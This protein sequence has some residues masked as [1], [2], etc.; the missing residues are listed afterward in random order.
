MKR[1]L[2]TG[3][4]VSFSLGLATAAQADI[5]VATAGP[6]TGQYAAFGTQ[7]KNGAELAVADINAAGGVLGK[8]L[9]LEIGDDACDPK[10]AVALLPFGAHKGYG[11][12]LINEIVAGFIGGSLPTIR[13]RD[14][15]EDGEKRSACFYFQVIHP[16]AISGGA[17]AAGR[18]QSSNVKAVI[19]DILGHGNQ[20]CLLPGQIEAAAAARSEKN[21]GLL[22]SEA[23]IQAFNDLAAE[24]GLPAW[25]AAA[26]PLAQ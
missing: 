3:I 16:D 5:S 22:F 26:L 25:E 15:K 21:G 4:A 11:L 8:K 13:N 23:E 9:T 7:F 17:F 6:M 20:S 2:M 1:L 14:W 24:C 19:D 12:S 18:N 10:Q